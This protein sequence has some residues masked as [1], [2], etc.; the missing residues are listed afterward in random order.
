MSLLCWSCRF[1]RCCCGG[2]S[3]L[4][5]V[6]RWDYP[7]VFWTKLMPRCW[8]ATTGAVKVGVALMCLSCTFHRCRSMPLLC[9]SS[10]LR[11]CRSMFLATGGRDALAIPSVL[12]EVCP[13]VDWVLRTGEVLNLFAGS[14]RCSTVG[15]RTTVGLNRLGV[16]RVQTWMVGVQLAH[17]KTLSSVVCVAVP[18]LMAFSAVRVHGVST[19]RA[20]THQCRE[21]HGVDD[22]HGRSGSLSEMWCQFSVVPWA[23][24]PDRQP[25]AVYKYWAACHSSKS[26]SWRVLLFCPH[27]LIL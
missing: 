6:G 27:R 8:C 3:T 19:L 5:V 13:G 10:K 26:R 4:T 9:R 11:R 21:N 17:I 7:H 22:L 23:Q 15:V 1:L 2:D 25:R 18:C 24:W 14:N 12:F 20:A 16:I